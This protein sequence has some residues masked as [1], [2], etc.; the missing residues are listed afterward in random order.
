MLLPPPSGRREILGG[1]ELARRRAVARRAAWG[2][3][4]G[5]VRVWGFGLGFGAAG[6]RRAPL[7]ATLEATDRGREVG[8]AVGMGGG[9][10]FRVLAVGAAARPGRGRGE[11]RG[12]ARVPAAREGKEGEDLPGGARTRRISVQG[13]RGS[14]IRRREPPET[15]RRA[16]RPDARKR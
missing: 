11:G 13:V 5:R 3:A 14:R 6:V 15:G 4:A 12:G 16:A 9:A 8:Q 7:P 1:D 10:A 2:L